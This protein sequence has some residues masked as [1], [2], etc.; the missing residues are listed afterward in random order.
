MPMVMRLPT[1]RD[2][3]NRH[4]NLL[5]MR[6][7][8]AK[9]TTYS[10]QSRSRKQNVMRDPDPKLP[11]S[12]PDPEQPG[13]PLPNPSPDEPG[14]DVVPLFDPGLPQPRML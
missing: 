7:S 10:F 5:P 12:D 1:D 6:R 13:P 9:C 3:E 8:G 4:V 2:K 14:P 11:P